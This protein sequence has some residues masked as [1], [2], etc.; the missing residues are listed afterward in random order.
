MTNIQQH[1]RNNPELLAALDKYRDRVKN[2]DAMRTEMAQIMEG[3]HLDKETIYLRA[4]LVSLLVGSMAQMG[5]DTSAL[6]TLI[7]GIGT[8]VQYPLVARDKDAE[9]TQE[10]LAR[11]ASDALQ[12]SLGVKTSFVEGDPDEVT[13]P[14]TIE[15]ETLSK[16]EAMERV[17]PKALANIKAGLHQQPI[18]ADPDMPVA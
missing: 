1:D 7:A 3:M 11:I 13:L 8:A 5:D 4:K 9:V 15:E 14:S 16:L 12:I 17:F 6:S 10:M 2:V 18:A